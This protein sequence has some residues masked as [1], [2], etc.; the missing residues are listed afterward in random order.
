MIALLP[1]TEKLIAPFL[2][3]RAISRFFTEFAPNVTIFAFLAELFPVA[4]IPETN[5]LS[6]EEF[7]A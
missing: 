3:I 7:S 6:L 1:R 4:L 2:V 5:G